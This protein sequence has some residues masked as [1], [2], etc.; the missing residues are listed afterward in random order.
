MSHAIQ[1][2]KPILPKRGGGGACPCPPPPKKPNR[3]TLFYT[4]LML[5]KILLFNFLFFDNPLIEGRHRTHFRLNLN[6]RK[7]QGV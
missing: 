4:V 6:P 7:Y 1:H 3:E 5:Q 2:Q